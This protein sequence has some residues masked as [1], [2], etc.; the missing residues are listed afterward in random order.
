MNKLFVFMI[1]ILAGHY[2]YKYRQAHYPRENTFDETNRMKKSNVVEYFDIIANPNNAMQYKKMGLVD[3]RNLSCLHSVLNILKKQS[4]FISFDYNG[5]PIMGIFACSTK[6]LSRV[7]DYM[8]YTQQDFLDSTLPNGLFLFFLM[9]RPKKIMQDSS[10][11][12]YLFNDLITEVINQCRTNTFDEYCTPNS[13]M[14][15]ILYPIQEY[16]I[17]DP[18]IQV[19]YENGFLKTSFRLDRI[20][21]FK[22][23]ITFH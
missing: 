8:Q 15:Y 9:I 22:K 7:L 18:I 20:I 1:M 5:K 3:E 16:H 19:L 21:F 4:K 17:D 10:N 11:I 2:A 13:R 6:K 12:K 23:Y 14:Q